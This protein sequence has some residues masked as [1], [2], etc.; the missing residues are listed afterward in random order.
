MDKNE[1]QLSI[2]NFT[3]YLRYFLDDSKD[4][5]KRIVLL[6]ESQK[7]RDEM[8]EELFVLRDTMDSLF[9]DFLNLKCDINQYI[10]EIETRDDED[11]E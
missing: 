7:E 9:K 5:L 11:N 3:L 1:L 2:D 8:R 4:I 6:E 10:Y